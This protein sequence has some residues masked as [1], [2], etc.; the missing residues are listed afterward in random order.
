MTPLH[1]PNTPHKMEIGAFKCLKAT[2]HVRGGKTCARGTPK[3]PTRVWYITVSR[4]DGRG[5]RYSEWV[6]G[7]QPILHSTT[8]GM[9]QMKQETTRQSLPN[10]QAA[11]CRII[12]KQVT[13]GTRFCQV[14]LL[15]I[16][17]RGNYLR[18]SRPTLLSTSQ[19]GPSSRRRCRNLRQDLLKFCD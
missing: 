15:S 2:K 1:K 11:E 16:T 13:K 12:G 19:S 6:T 3:Y 4:W 7:G 10:R 18:T 5:I 14:I 8:A 17:S 9:P